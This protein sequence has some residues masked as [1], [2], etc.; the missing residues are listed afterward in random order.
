[1]PVFNCKDTIN[2]NGR[3]I[4]LSVPKIM[5]IINI[6]PDSFYKGSRFTDSSKI[7]AQVQ[8]MITDG[9]DVIDIGGYSTRPGAPL[10]HEHEE[11]NR[12]SPALDA[13][14][15]KFPDIMISVDTF[16]S[17]IVKKGIEQYKI[18]IVND[19]SAGELDPDMFQMV[20]QMQVPYVLMHMQGTPQN[21]QECP[22]YAFIVQE[23]ITYL[24]KKT[25]ELAKCGVKD[26]IIDPGFGFGKTL[27]HNFT[28]LN[29]LNE[30]K[31]LELP[32]LVGISRKS[33][34]YKTLNTNP[35]EA[36]NGTTV[37]NTIALQK[38]AGILRVHDVKAAFEAVKLVT[39]MQQAN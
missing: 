21:M 20:G 22:N 25:E 26:I 35:E 29:R 33:M 32:I 13:I 9:A 7:V 36:L 28:L 11:W 19:I 8:Q 14:R 2:C 39:R 1:M 10:V 6:T 4:D 24:A 18:S 34:I 23:I 12:L 37:L 5:G 38:G 27:D 16:R 17:S 15:Q 3:L 31:M 30:F